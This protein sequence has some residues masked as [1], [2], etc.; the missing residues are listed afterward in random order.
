[1][2][3]RLLRRTG[4]RCPFL[5]MGGTFQYKRVRQGFGPSGDSYTRRT[6][7]ILPAK[8]DNHGILDME[9]IVDDILILSEIMDEPFLARACGVPAV[10]VRA[11]D[12]WQTT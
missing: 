7:D 4:A 2:E 1:M 11:V 5:Q 12:C 6:D 3:L 8:P 9:T 10:G